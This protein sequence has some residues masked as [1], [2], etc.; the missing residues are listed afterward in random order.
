MPWSGTVWNKHPLTVTLGFFQEL[1]NTETTTPTR[2]VIA[3]RTVELGPN[4]KTSVD[5][6]LR[7]DNADD[8]DLSNGGDAAPFGRLFFCILNEEDGRCPANNEYPNLEGVVPPPNWIPQPEDLG[9]APDSTNHFAGAAMTAYPGVQ[10]DFPTVFDPATGAIQGPKHRNPRP[11]HLG[12]LVSREAEADGGPDADGVNNIWP[13]ANANDQDWF[14]DGAQLSNLANCQPARANVRVAV[15]QQA[16]NWF[17][18]NERVAYLNVWLD[19]NHDGDWADGF[20]CVDEAGQ[21]KDVVEHILIDYP[22]DVAALG[23][24]LHN[25]S[26]I[27]TERVGWPAQ[28]AQEARWFRFTLSEEPANKPLTFNGIQHGDGRGFATAFRTGETEDYLQVL[29]S[30][31]GDIG[32]G[33]DLALRVAGQIVPREGATTRGTAVMGSDAELRVKFDYANLGAVNASGARLTLNKQIL[34]VDAGIRGIQGPGIQPGDVI[35]NANRI[36]I[37]LPDLLPTQ[38]GSLVMRLGLPSGQAAVA[39]ALQSGTYTLTAQIELAGDIDPSNNMA[40]TTVAMPNAPLR[41]AATVAG[42]D[43]LRKADTTCRDEVWFKGRGE[44]FTDIGVYVNESSNIT[45]Q[46]DANGL[47]DDLRLTNLPAGR[48]RV[49][50]N[51]AGHAVMSPR[52]AARGLAVG[53]TIDTSLPVDPITLL[54]TDSQG[55]QFHPPT[56]GWAR[57]ASQIDNW[58]LQ[59][60]ETYTISISTCVAD[61]NMA[62]RL[63][64]DDELRGI[65]H[66]DD[67]DGVYTGSFTYRAPVQAS[68]L[69]TSNAASQLSLVVETRGVE[70][71]FAAALS[72]LVQGMITDGATNQPVG[73]ASITA[74]V[75]NGRMGASAITTAESSQPAPQTTGADG[76]YGFTV[77]DDV[78]RLAVTANGYQPYQTD[79]IVVTDGHLVEVVKLTP[80][81]SEPA[82]HTVFITANGFAPANLTVKP[83]EAVDWVNADLVEHATSAAGQWDSGLLTTGDS[84]KIRLT[85]EGTYAYADESGNVGRVVVDAKPT[86]PDKP[87]GQ[88]KALFLPIIRR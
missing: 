29:P 25:L 47:I 36:A 81:I 46:A 67:G 66:D 2:E 63:F 54:L 43:L 16:V 31:G 17:G 45:I 27:A 78:Y 22:I 49:W 75:V 38:S 4:E 87:L 21:N 30:V 3:L 50:L 1:V 60:D 85:A 18:N 24:G 53:L 64:I 51:Y 72:P 74:L 35:S 34:N 83:G 26:N 13:P 57:G 12:P 23:V 56:L 5:L 41:L 59:A 48:N 28:G 39:A 37:A 82:D 33:P 80:A 70:Q 40:S 69:A 76:R 44:P 86:E 71:R 7:L 61:Q 11:L 77:A 52:D 15:N 62:A 88:K 55:R 10:A 42:D 20:T 19:S 58:P 9:D 14:D 8:D 68:G 73:A 32:S 6:M 79:D 65:L 84:Y